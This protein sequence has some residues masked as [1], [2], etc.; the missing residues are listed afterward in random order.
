MKN[1]ILIASALVVLV[2]MTTGLIPVK[3]DNKKVMSNFNIKDISEHGLV[4][5]GPDDKSFSSLLDAAL[6]LRPEASR[7][8]LQ[9]HVI[10]LKNEG[11]QVVVAYS[12]KWEFLRADGTIVTK[13]KSYLNRSG[14][15]GQE[16]DRNGGQTINPGDTWFF[17]LTDVFKVEATDSSKLGAGNKMGIRR[18]N[19]NSLAKEMATYTGVTV[20][21]D[22]VFFDDGT[23][24]GPDTTDFFTETKARRS[25]RLDLMLELEKQVKEGKTDNAFKQMEGFVKEPVVKRSGR[26]TSTDYYNL[27]KRRYAEELLEVRKALGDEEAAKKILSSLRKTWPELRK[28]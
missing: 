6:Q 23:F 16:E 10:F 18:K 26:P 3:K 24:V 19:P 9:S 21:L 11:R 13:R 12:L 15:M 22:G 20:S 4:I 2:M 28:L 14:L 7:E 25:A 1:I 5:I 17:S 8:D 27:N